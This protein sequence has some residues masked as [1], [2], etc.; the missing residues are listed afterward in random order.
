MRSIGVGNIEIH[1]LADGRIRLPAPFFPGLDAQRHPG[2]F[3]DDGTVHVPTGAF[4]V[5]GGGRTILVDAGLGP[6][7]IEFPE[8]QRPDDGD[9][10][11]GGGLPIALA[12]AGCSPADVDTIVLTHLHSDHVG[13]LAPQGKPYFPNAVVH[14]GAPDWAAL[15]DPVGRHDWTRMGLETV[16]AQGHL[17]ELHGDVEIAPGIVARHAPGHTP[18]HY[19][20][21]VTADD[22][23]V[24]LLG[25]V[26]HTPAQLVDSNVRFISDTDPSLAL[27]TRQQ[28]L[29]RVA[30]TDT[31]VAPA[32][33]PGMQFFRVSAD[34][35]AEPVD[36]VSV[37]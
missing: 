14:Y 22:R 18:G 13:W 9:M 20:V 12:A 7:E 8:G 24:V 28:W 29:R 17:E 2:A 5:R 34:R 25:D 15:V 37:G 36:A 19:V 23:R 3:A 31:I 33:F 26:L 35:V 16:R 6:R 1:A 4:L 27:L 32:H 11:A 21:D 10:G 30:G